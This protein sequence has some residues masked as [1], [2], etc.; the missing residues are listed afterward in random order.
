MSLVVIGNFDGVHRGHQAVL[1]S[2]AELAAARDLSPKLFT[3]E[4][5]PA[6]TLG[7]PAPALLTTLERKRELCARF[8]PGIELVVRRFDRAFAEQSP[9]TFVERVL[10]A[11]LHAKAVLVGDN[12]RFG[13]DRAG[14]IDDLQ[15]FGREHGFTAS[16]EPMVSD[17]SG[18]WS[19]TRIR[20]AIAEGDLAAARDMLGRP[21]MLSGPVVAGQRRGRTIGF[22]TCN[23]ASPPEALPPNGVYAVLVDRV[24]GG[25]PHALAKG[26]ANL[27]L[28]PTV[29]D[30]AIEPVLEVHLF[31]VDA[32][33]YGAM[34]R[35]HLIEGLRPEQRFSSFD[36]LRAQIQADAERARAILDSVA[37]PDG[38]W[39]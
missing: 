8:C 2:V 25:T 3:F 18:A 10:V 24:E 31:D 11:E 33:L 13:R 14:T 36:A 7:R 20:A 27:G 12:F 6:V 17:D 5:H 38:A 21:H 34:L 23:L 32:D 30:G 4:P 9:A 16:A 1:R 29:D 28:R 39:H 26:V 19:S 35:V 37:H 22:P 15:R